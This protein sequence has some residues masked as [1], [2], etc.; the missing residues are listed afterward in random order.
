MSKNGPEGQESATRRQT[1]TAAPNRAKSRPLTTQADEWIK[2]SLEDDEVR[3]A[4][5]PH[6]GA[7]GA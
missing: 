6:H 1:E 4:L 7:R 5:K 2:E 3:E